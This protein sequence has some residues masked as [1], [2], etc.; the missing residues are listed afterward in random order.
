MVASLCCCC[1]PLYD[2][3]R[4]TFDSNPNQYLSTI[5]YYL[6]TP[7]NDFESDCDYMLSSSGFLPSKD[8]YYN[9]LFYKDSNFV[10]SESKINILLSENFKDYYELFGG[11]PCDYLDV[12]AGNLDFLPISFFYSFS[13]KILEI[14]CRDI[15]HSGTNSNYGVA[16]EFQTNP[17]LPN[18]YEGFFSYKIK[19]NNYYISLAKSFIIPIVNDLLGFDNY[20]IKIIYLSEV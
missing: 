14:H 20:E 4:I 17:D 6:I 13:N 19:D 1:C 15:T 7:I 2:S 11:N 10:A 3:F 16:I 5:P 12:P 8:I 18:T 9:L